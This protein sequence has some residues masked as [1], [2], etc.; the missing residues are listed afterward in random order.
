M[1][2][3]VNRINRTI[4]W[5]TLLLFIGVVFA[6]QNPVFSQTN[7]PSIEYQVKASLI[8][9]FLQYVIWPSNENAAGSIIHLC[10]VGEDN[11]GLALSALDGEL[12]LGRQIEVVG[13]VPPDKILDAHC[14]VIYFS[15]RMRGDPAKKLIN[16]ELHESTILTIGEYSDFL[17]EGGIINLSIDQ[18]KIVF[19]INR[20]NAI[21]ARLEISSKLLRMARKI[22]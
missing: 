12:V 11:F 8:F 3:I 18:K 13:L 19:D 10:I 4:I 17:D 14:E 16:E 15:N 20:R 22:Q 5:P 1:T 2:K 9:N 6:A 7:R 21:K